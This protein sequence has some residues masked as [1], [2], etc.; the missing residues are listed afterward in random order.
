M[1]QQIMMKMQ[2]R[3]RP[4]KPKGKRAALVFEKKCKNQKFEKKKQD[5]EK[6]R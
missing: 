5:E 4:S 6:R 2:K 3:R 1:F